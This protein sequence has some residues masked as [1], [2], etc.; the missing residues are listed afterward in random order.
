MISGI[1]RNGSLHVK[2]AAGLG[3]NCCWQ[4][5]PSW[6][7]RSQLTA[8]PRS[9]LGSWGVL[10]EAAPLAC[11]AIAQDTGQPRTSA[12]AARVT[13]SGTEQLSGGTCPVEHWNTSCG[14]RPEEHVLRNTP[15]RTRPAEHVLQN[16]P[17]RT[18]PVNDLQGQQS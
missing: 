9:T 2:S 12:Q 16:M 11:Q 7:H 15:C 5:R 14:T 3:F 18:C 17:C 6:N 10:L 8:G 4:R 1:G 13:P